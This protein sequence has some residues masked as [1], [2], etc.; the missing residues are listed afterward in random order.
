M[1]T[2][3]NF[4]ALE[5]LISAPFTAFLADN[6]VNLSLIPR[7]CEALVRDGVIGAFVCGT[8]GEGLSLSI[9]ERKQVA[10]T[11]MEVAP[12]NFRVIVHVGH[13]SLAESRELASHAAAI[14]AFGIGAFP[15]FFFTTHS[16]EVLAEMCAEIAGAAFPLPFSLLSYPFYDGYRY[17]DA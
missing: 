5:G 12:P 4:P 15:P 2:L 3:H 8:T 6:S 17:P 7:Q 9:E 1:T 13:N 16:P 10:E 11:W 14:G